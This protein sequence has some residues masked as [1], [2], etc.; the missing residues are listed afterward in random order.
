MNYFYDGYKFG[1]MFTFLGWLDNLKGLGMKWEAPF[2]FGILKMISFGMDYHWRLQGGALSGE[3]WIYLLIIKSE[4][5]RC[6][7]VD[8]LRNT[9]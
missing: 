7:V 3:V 6:S 5:P 8:L 9:D 1:D 2:N 4:A